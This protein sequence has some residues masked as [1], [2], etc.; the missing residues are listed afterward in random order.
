MPSRKLNIYRQ[1]VTWKAYEILER[2]KS[3]NNNK[4]IKILPM[5]T[6]INALGALIFSLNNELNV[7]VVYDNPRDEKSAEDKIG[8]TYIY[9]ISELLN[10]KEI[11]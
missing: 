2:I 4:Y 7:E 11:C 9:D 1:I 8:S 3:V 10:A 5:G 6:K